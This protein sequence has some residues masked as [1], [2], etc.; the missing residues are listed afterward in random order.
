MI[1]LQSETTII[2]DAIKRQYWFGR[3]MVAA[4]ACDLEVLGELHHIE[5]GQQLT[6]AEALAY[7]T[8]VLHAW[9]KV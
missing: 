1:D 7:P 5:P 6:E 8:G 3:A 2:Q 4:Q 9:V